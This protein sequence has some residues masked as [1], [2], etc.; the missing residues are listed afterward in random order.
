[1]ICSG[2]KELLSEIKKYMNLHDIQLKE[3]AIRMGK[4]QQSVSQYFNNGNPKLEN[5][6]EICHALGTDIDFNLIP[7][8]K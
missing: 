8:N 2:S 7:N 4:S 5:V 6:F 3:L 1:M